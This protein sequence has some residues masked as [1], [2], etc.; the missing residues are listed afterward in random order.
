MTLHSARTL[1]NW[2]GG[3]RTQIVKPEPEKEGEEWCPGLGTYQPTIPS[4]PL[5]DLEVERGFDLLFLS[6]LSSLHLFRKLECVR[7]SSLTQ[8]LFL[9]IFTNALLVD[10]FSNPFPW[11]ERLSFLTW[12]GIDHILLAPV[13][14]DGDLVSQP[15]SPAWK[16]HLY[17]IPA[18]LAPD[19]PCS[20]SF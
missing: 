4:L 10:W 6:L 16:L 9:C 13:F 7:C 15:S 20:C 17:D 14:D 12:V 8:P 11:F 3:P 18:S 1:S 2:S 19:K 5:R